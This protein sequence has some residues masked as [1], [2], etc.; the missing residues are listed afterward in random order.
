MNKSYALIED[1]AKE[2]GVEVEYWSEIINPYIYQ[3]II[4]T[5]DVVLNIIMNAIKY[6]PKGGKVKFG[7]KQ[8]PGKNDNECMIDFICE[9]NG[10]GISEDFLPKVYTSFEREDN[11]VN[12]E[13]PSAGLGLYIAKSLITL[14]SG[15]IDITSQKGQ[16]TVVRTSQPH[17]YAKREDIDSDSFLIDSGN[18]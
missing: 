6:T 5:A 8:T 2:K 1:K 3:D 16:G 12:R 14:M 13:N 9:D 7:I 15:T 11:E 17:R 10:I 4:H 18:L